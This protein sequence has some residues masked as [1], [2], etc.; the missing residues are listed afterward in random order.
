MEILG[1]KALDGALQ[2]LQSQPSEANHDN[3]W[4]NDYDWDDAGVWG[5]QD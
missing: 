5:Q 2:R 3:D 4:E 1:E